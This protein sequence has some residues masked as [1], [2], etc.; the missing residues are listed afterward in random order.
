MTIPT[1]TANVTLAP[2]EELDVVV[3]A[4]DAAGNE[5][6]EIPIERQAP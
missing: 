6:D 1:W 4:C 2:D 3:T 5:A